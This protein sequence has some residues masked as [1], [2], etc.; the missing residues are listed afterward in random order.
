MLES[1]PV[2]G[3]VL[4]LHPSNRARLL[5]PGLIL[6]G[7]VSYTL[8]L[9]FVESAPLLV[10]LGTALVALVVGW[11]SLHLWNREVILYERG[12]TYREGSR[13]VQFAYSEIAGLRQRA[14]Q[15]GY[16]GGLFKRTVYEYR[17]TTQAGEILILN[18]LY[19]GIDRLG[20]RLEER[21][22]AALRPQLEARWAKGESVVFAEHFSVA[23]D[24]L[25][26]D[27]KRLSWGQCAG[28]KIEGGAL[29]VLQVASRRGEEEP[30]PQPLSQ[31]EGRKEAAPLASRG[32][33]DSG[34]P[35]VA[36]KGR[37][38]ELWLRLPLDGVDNIALLVE[39]IKR[40][41]G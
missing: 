1:D 4:A 10:M 9:L 27:D 21:I 24:G 33:K 19:S 28:Y 34:S 14:E 23:Q 35:S 8:N 29:L 12:F 13:I 26:S 5:I 25:Q 17:L 18:N 32:E 40:R 39:T 30:H 41:A 2:L 22:N 3:R 31:G 15:L 37:G 38:G 16:F 36:E 6:V 20:E 7:T 11:R